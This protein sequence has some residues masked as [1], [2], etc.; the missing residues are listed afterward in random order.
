[1]SYRVTFLTVLPA[2]YMQEHFAALAASSDFDVRV[3]Y[4][5]QHASDREW[6]KRTLAPYETVLPGTTFSWLGRSAHLNPGIVSHLRH[7]SADLVVI[8]DYSAPTAQLAMRHLNQVGRPWVFWGEMPGIHERNAVGRW[9]RNRLQRPIVTGAAAVAAIGSRAAKV[10]G[11]L[12]GEH[13]PVANIPYAC[14]LDRFRAAKANR[15]VKACDD[16]IIFLFSGQLIYRKGAD[17]LIRAFSEMADRAPMMRL[18]LLGGGPERRTLEALVPP[19][20]A[21]RV[22][23]RGFVQPD[24][25]PAAF[26]EA[27]VFVLPSRHDGWGIV[28]NEALGAGLPIVASDRVGAAYDLVQMEVNGFIVPTEDVGALAAVLETLGSSKL[29]RSTYGEASRSL[30]KEWDLDR[31]V[32][33]WAGLCERVLGVGA[34]V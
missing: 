23:F 22:D 3:L 6:K 31:A 27:D 34:T 24:G 32:G 17:V 12:V 2:P 9:L 8:S 20:L 29:L 21:E 16:P 33:R 28:I 14:D 7:D 5:T 11:T 13:I 4:Y 30:S 15:T 18:V 19:R 10:Y 25:L 26:A 1:M